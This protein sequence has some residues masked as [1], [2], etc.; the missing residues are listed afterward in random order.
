MTKPLPVVG[1]ERDTWG[2]KLNEYL[3]ELS[4]TTAAKADV[5]DTDTL[6]AAKVA[7]PASLTRVVLDTTYVTA[8]ITGEDDVSLYLDGV[9]L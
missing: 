2:E 1:A 8:I 9:E 4:E 7:N 5:A 3:A 6:V